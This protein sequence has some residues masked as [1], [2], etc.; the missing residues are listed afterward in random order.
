VAV[1]T[2]WRLRAL[3]LAATGLARVSVS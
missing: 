2:C 1:K 3:M